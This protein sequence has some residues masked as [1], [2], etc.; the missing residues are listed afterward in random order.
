MKTHFF[1]IDG[2]N[3][4]CLSIFYAKNQ[5]IYLLRHLKKFYKTYELL[6][7]FFYYRFSIIS[8]ER[9]DLIMTFKVD[10]IISDDIEA[11]FQD[12]V[13]KN[14]SKQ[15]NNNKWISHTIWMPY[16]NNSIEWKKIHI[17]DIILKDNVTR[18]ELFQVSIIGLYLSDLIEDIDS[19]LLFLLVKILKYPIL[20][21]LDIFSQL[22]CSD[23]LQLVL[24]TELLDAYL[25]YQ[26]QEHFPKQ[27]LSKWEKCNELHYL[28]NQKE[29][30]FNAYVN[31]REQ[32]GV[33]SKKKNEQLTYI[34]IEYLRE[35]IKE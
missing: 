19:I 24:N 6:L 1:E 31:L 18:E 29:H 16:N 34:L 27:C 9:L 33:I 35:K 28:E 3:W 8:G 4:Y 30:F 32:Y 13:K 25:N 17:P 22:Y 5:W 26:F 14:P 20:Q 10:D 11:F 23:S 12:F 7:D 21:K 2:I 15:D